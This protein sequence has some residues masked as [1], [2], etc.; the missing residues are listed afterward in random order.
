MS[1][2]EQ[3]CFGLN[4][5]EAAWRNRNKCWAGCYNQKVTEKQIKIMPITILKTSKVD[6]KSVLRP[7]LRG[8]PN[9]QG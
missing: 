1:P 8:E 2:W 5:F 3:A 6:A 7:T 4:Y 9:N